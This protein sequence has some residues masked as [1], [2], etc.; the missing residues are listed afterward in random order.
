MASLN[1]VQL[2]FCLRTCLSES[3]LG[4]KI[5]GV[6]ALALSAVLGSWV[7]SSVALSADELIAVVLLSE[8]LERWLNNTASESEDQVKGALLLDVVVREGS[9]VLELL[10]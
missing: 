6:T 3:L 9:A 2:P 8:D 1:G 5:V 4:S 7:E 10:T